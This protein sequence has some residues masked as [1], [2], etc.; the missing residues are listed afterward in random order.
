MRCRTALV[1]LVCL[2]S[3]ARAPAHTLSEELVLVDTDA[4][5]DDLRAIALLARLP[6]IEVM[7]IVTG[8]GSAAADTGAVLVRAWLRRLGREDIHV[9]AGKRSSRTPPPWRML[10]DA[11]YA[12]LPE[13][14]RGKTPPLDWRRE[15]ANRIAAEPGRITVLA[16]GPLTNLAE[17]LKADPDLARR[18]SRVVW[19]GSPPEGPASF[20]RDFDPEAARQ[21]WASGVPVYPVASG[22]S[23]AEELVFDQALL[24][25]LAQG[26]GAPG[27]ALRW[28][29]SVPAARERLK[30]GHYR[31]WD[32][33]AALY[34][35]RPESFVRT[36]GVWTPEPAWLRSALVHFF[37]GPAGIPP[38]RDNESFDRF[39]MVPDGFRADLAA[40]INEIV[41][42]HGPDEFRAC[43]LV[44][45]LHQ[46]LGIYSILGAKMSLR[47][48][49]ILAEPDHPL[50]VVSFAG[51]SPPLSCLNDGLQVGAGATLGLG[52]I[53][54]DE[55][56][57]PRPAATFWA[58]TK[59]VTLAVRPE[60]VERIA[61]EIAALKARHGAFDAGYYR[62]L[63][64]LAIRLW[65]E[66]DR[67]LIFSEEPS[68]RP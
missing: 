51:S 30:A 40:H 14:E 28:L 54:V 55:K 20:N 29:F 53:R 59:S 12:S 6:G 11:L 44:S 45:E 64:A 21:L 61:K 36:D 48:R 10:S 7:G 37:R 19:Y 13:N 24:E 33:A 58:D 23:R 15:L 5:L 52:M 50:R 47:A 32:E 41:S 65:R 8:D 43:V 42:R 56:S 67:K 35:I 66:L 17:L 4:G 34:L 46:H 60:V 26:S 3:Y 38:A 1:L 22:R 9:F 25:E 63:R 27:E 49:E 57:P 68:A 16:L 39:P 62:E 2:F 18:L 31:V